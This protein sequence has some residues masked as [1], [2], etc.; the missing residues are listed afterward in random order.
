VRREWFEEHYKLLRV[1]LLA[2]AALNVWL[3]YAILP[4]QPI[5]AF[6]NGVMAAVIVFGVSVS[7]HSK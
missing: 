1:L 4:E 2:L 7:W 3:A 6:A 5:M